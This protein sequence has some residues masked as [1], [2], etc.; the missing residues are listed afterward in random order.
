MHCLENTDCPG[1]MVCSANNVCFGA[2]K[3]EPCPEGVQCGTGLACVNLNS[4]RVCLPSCNLYQPVCEMGELCFRLTYESS[5]SLVFESQG[6]IGVCYRQPT[7]L[8]GPRELC[9][10]NVMG[11]SNCQPNLQCVPDTA[12][13][14]LCRAYCSPLTSGSCVGSDKCVPFVGDFNG[15][16]YG[17]CLPDTGFGATCT[18]DAQCRTGLSCQPYDDPSSFNRLSPICQFNLGAQ[19]GLAPCAPRVTDAGVIAADLACRSGAC[20]GDLGSQYFCFAACATDSDCAIGGRAG[21]C[22]TDFSFVSAFGTAGTVRGCRPGCGSAADCDRFDA[23]VTCSSRVVVETSTSA[24]LSQ[25]CT[26]PQGGLGAFEPC[27]ANSQCRSGLC[28]T[29][30]ARGVSRSGVCLEPCTTACSS[31][32]ADA[33]TWLPLECADST[34][35]GTRGLDGVAN[36]T[37]DVTAQGRFC[38]GR[39]CQTSVDCLT[40]AGVDS[41]CAPVFERTGPAALSLRCSAKAGFRPGGQ[42]CFSD[43]ECVS[44]ACGTLQ[45]PS[46]GTGRVCFEA[47][48]ASSTCPAATS[49]RVGGLSLMTARGPVTVDTCAP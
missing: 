45:S 12:S 2:R 30:D 46:V 36:T 29:I 44:G 15:R 13:T 26:S 40:D 41:V 22:D 25:V 24:K 34:L 47:C 7:G 11:G 5:N 43:T 23:G 6:P 21:S 31:R 19:E 4:N 9:E 28:Q 20:R 14:S 35:F 10:R 48:T 38:Q 37:D 42:T 16:R 33:G 17:L 3:G 18:R 27:V 39:T 49:C 32:Q 8:K 1:G